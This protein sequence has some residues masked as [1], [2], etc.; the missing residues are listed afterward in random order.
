MK[1]SKERHEHLKRISPLGAK[2]GWANKTK[3]EKSAEMARRRRLGIENK[4]KK[5][6]S[7]RSEEGDI[8]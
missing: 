2:A 6:L 3:E 7:T 1:I 4:R 8:T 5:F